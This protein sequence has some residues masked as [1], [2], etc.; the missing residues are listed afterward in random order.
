[1]TSPTDG[2]SFGE[3]DRDGFDLA[4]CD[5]LG[6][7]T[8]AEWLLSAGCW[9]EACAGDGVAFMAP[10]PQAAV[11]RMAAMGRMNRRTRPPKAVQ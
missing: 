10:G 2:H 1:M 6:V 11:S 8:A 5:A 7:F 9:D 3:A 4:E